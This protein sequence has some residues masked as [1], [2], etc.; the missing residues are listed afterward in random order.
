MNHYVILPVLPGI[1]NFFFAMKRSIMIPAI[2]LSLLVWASGCSG[3]VSQPVLDPANVESELRAFEDAHRDA[4]D[5]K[6]IEG[7]LQFYSTDL[8]TVTQ[9]E[10]IQY[11]ND[12]IRPLM[13]E[14]Y[15]SYDFHENFKLDD[16]EIIGDRVVATLQYSQKMTPLKGGKTVIE[17]GKGVCVLKKSDTGNWQFEW[18]CYNPDDTQPNVEE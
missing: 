16:V 3:P 2:V 4:I 7:I 10:P 18:N 14:L 13:Q 9:G 12:W 6:D 5:K 8:I 1:M 15:Q 17:T 11:G